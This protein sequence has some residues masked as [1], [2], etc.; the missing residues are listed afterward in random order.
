[1]NFAS[2]LSDIALQTLL[3]MQKFHELCFRKGH[4][5]TEIGIAEFL[6]RCDFSE[7]SVLNLSECGNLSNSCAVL[8]GAHCPNLSHLFLCWC[9]E[10]GDAG[11]L[12]IVSRCHKM[13]E[14]DLTGQ[15]INSGHV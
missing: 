14:M 7:L 11:I 12:T 6:S 3:P 15:S 4:S 9:W 2:S 1:M 8:I 13:V 10:V 5:F